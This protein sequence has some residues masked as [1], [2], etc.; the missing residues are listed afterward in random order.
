MDWQTLLTFI[1]VFLAGLHIGMRIGG[2][3]LTKTLRE[4]EQ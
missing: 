1:S 4:Q 3:W 2:W